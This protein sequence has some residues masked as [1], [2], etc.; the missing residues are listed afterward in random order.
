MKI[1]TSVILLLL[2][3]VAS[4][5]AR[6]WTREA[7]EIAV[8]E[9]WPACPFERLGELRDRDGRRGDRTVNQNGAGSIERYGERVDAGKVYARL[10]LQARAL[11]GNAVVIRGRT[12]MRGPA[13]H[14]TATAR[15]DEGLEVTA[16]AISVADPAACGL[17]T[18]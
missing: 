6:D 1:G 4:G 14:G 8:L 12:N 16:V 17:A 11:G 3:T 13:G 18:R 9:R 5:C 15:P 7:S 2:A 10:R